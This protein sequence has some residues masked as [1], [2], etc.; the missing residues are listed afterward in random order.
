MIITVI[1]EKT[2]ELIVDFD[3]ESGSCI[4]MNGY[5]V[6]VSEK[7]DRWISVKDRLPEGGVCCLLLDK[8]G[9]YSVGYCCGTAYNGSAIFHTKAHDGGELHFSI[10]HW[11]PLPES[12]REETK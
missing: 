9:S 7:E 3:S 12:P 5:S 10:T 11:M 2:R 8:Y 4:C 1:N 6:N